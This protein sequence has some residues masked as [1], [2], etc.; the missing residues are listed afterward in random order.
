M[1]TILLAPLY[2]WLISMMFRPRTPEDA[3]VQKVGYDNLPR[4]ESEIVSI[5][6]F[7][8]E[9]TQAHVSEAAVD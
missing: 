8:T 9:F 3:S 6:P 5:I 4:R 1:L 7:S 2:Y